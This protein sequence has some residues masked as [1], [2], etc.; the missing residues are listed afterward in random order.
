[1][2]IY[3][4]ITF[5]NIPLKRPVTHSGGLGDWYTSLGAQTLPPEKYFSNFIFQLCLNKKYVKVAINDFTMYLIISKWLG[6]QKCRLKR[7]TT[8][9]EVV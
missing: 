5:I 3:I 9:Q 1:M 8:R 6:R 4:Y 7:K 2:Y